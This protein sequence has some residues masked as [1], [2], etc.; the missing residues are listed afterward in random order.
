MTAPSTVPVPTV[1]GPLAVW[2]QNQKKRHLLSTVI[3]LGLRNPRKEE[4]RGN[5]ETKK[6]CFAKIDVEQQPKK[7]KFFNVKNSDR[8][9]MEKSH[10]GRTRA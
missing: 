1:L 6:D 7:K 8:P 4:R 9:R 3:R 2:I 5:K 10:C